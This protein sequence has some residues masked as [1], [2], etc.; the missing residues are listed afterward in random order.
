MI[1]EQ[2][3]TDDAPARALAFKVINDQKGSLTFIRVYSGVIKKGD[4]ILNVTRDKRERA[5]RMVEVQA[6]ISKEIDEAARATFA[7]WS[8]CARPKPAIR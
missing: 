1:G 4:Q 8:P 5:G 7:R 2:E 6:N 3:V